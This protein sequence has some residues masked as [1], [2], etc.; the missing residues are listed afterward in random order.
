MKG[1][2]RAGA[3]VLFMT[4][5]PLVWAQSAVQE[6]NES[7]PFGPPMDDQRIYVHAALEQFEYRAAGTQSLSR[8]EGEAWLGTDGQRLWFKSEGEVSRD[9][10]VAGGIH[11]LLYDRPVSSYF[12]MQA[13]VRYDKDSDPGRTWAAVGVEGLA[14]YRFRVALTGYVG[15]GGRLAARAQGFYDLLV[16]QRLILQPQ[17]ELNVYSKADPERRIGS[18]VSE[19]DAGIRLRY[20]ITRKFA[21]YF[22]VTFR[23][24]FAR[25]ADLERA[26][27]GSSQVLSATIGVRAWY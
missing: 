3:V 19:V 14:P 16:T 23:H 9:G 4:A 5:A 26:S 2:A 11:E 7:A 12:D 25:T 20:E 17:I 22:G 6:K 21:P 8:W 15:T 27:G 10:V 13:G 1:W 18:G 24:S